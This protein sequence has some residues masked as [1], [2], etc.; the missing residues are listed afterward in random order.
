[1]WWELTDFSSTTGTNSTYW[2]T[3]CMAWQT[4]SLSQWIEG[5]PEGCP[6]PCGFLAIV[7][8]LNP[9]WVLKEKVGVTKSLPKHRIRAQESHVLSFQ[10][11]LVAHILI[12]LAIG[13]RQK[14][15]KFKAGLGTIWKL[16]I[17]RPCGPVKLGLAAPTKQKRCSVVCFCSETR[18]HY[19]VF[20]SLTCLG[21]MALHLPLLPK[22]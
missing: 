7:L 1:M 19:V 5:L 9:S 11:D 12:T 4:V 6:S 20:V 22:C 16:Y 13:R 2:P 21:F 14:D 18:S 17:V 8:A 3:T 10:L 15:L